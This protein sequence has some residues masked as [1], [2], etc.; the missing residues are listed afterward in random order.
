MRPA[1]RDGRPVRLSTTHDQSRWVAARLE[2]LLTGAVTIA[3]GLGLG[4][5]CLTGAQGIADALRPAGV[6]AE[7]RAELARRR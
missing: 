1:Y 4:W 2:A 3:A 6:V 7:A 5:V